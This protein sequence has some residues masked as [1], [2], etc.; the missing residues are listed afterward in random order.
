MDDF[1]EG[2]PDETARNLLASVGGEGVSPVGHVNNRIQP[3]QKEEMQ[4]TEE[5]EL[6]LMWPSRQ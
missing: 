6:A 1:N 5:D 4:E 2:G 3:Q